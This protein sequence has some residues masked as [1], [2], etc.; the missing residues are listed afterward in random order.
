MKV[1]KKMQVSEAELFD[2][3]LTSA[4][5]DVEKATGK[6]AD[7]E[8][9]FSY[10]KNL[11]NKLGKEASAIG[12]FTKVEAPTAYE[13]EFKTARGI[14]K[15]AYHLEKADDGGI[16]VSYEELYDA[17]DSRHSLNDRIVSFFYKRAS[18]KRMLHMLNLME[19]YILE[20]R[21]T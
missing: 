5:A 10:R 12:T 11:T 21:T 16:L 4:K 9:G 13:V 14:N 7:I 15:I 1:E 8:T 20:Q 18:K 19:Q 3:I 2:L 17:V 6:T